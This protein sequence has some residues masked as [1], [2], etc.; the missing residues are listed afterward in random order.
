MISTSTS[1]GAT[2]RRP[3][4][5]AAAVALFGT[6]AMGFRGSAL[7][8]EAKA[9]AAEHRA[10]MLTPPPEKGGTVDDGFLGFAPAE[11][12]KGPLEEEWRK[13]GCVTCPDGGFCCP[14]LGCKITE[15]VLIGGNEATYQ[16]N[17]WV[18]HGNFPWYAY[19]AIPVLSFTHPVW[20][21][22]QINKEWWLYCFQ[23]NAGD[24]DGDGKPDY[25]DEE[26]NP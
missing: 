12:A 22:L 23:N 9:A 21:F 13:Q 1:S 26:H 14:A 8:N 17:L 4:I 5:A 7:V 18:E 6:T 19:P 25:A 10:R 20:T 11:N 16:T 2:W 3:L 24:S 15:T